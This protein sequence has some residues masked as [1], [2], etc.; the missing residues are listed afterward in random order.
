[1]GKLE[2][3]NSQ[4]YLYKPRGDKHC[5]SDDD[6]YFGDI[7]IKEEAEEAKN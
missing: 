2:R 1:M 4:Q 5:Y 6:E 7:D 3:T